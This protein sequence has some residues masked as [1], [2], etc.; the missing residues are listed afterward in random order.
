MNKSRKKY[1]IVF[2]ITISIFIAVF[3]LVDFLDAK[4]RQNISRLQS[5]ITIDLIANETQ[6]DLL[7][8]APCKALDEAILSRQL[9]ELGEKLAYAEETQGV[10]NQAVV[11]LKKYYSLLQVKDYLL[12]QEVSDKCDIQI[13]SL[14][15]FY[16]QD[17]DSCVKQGYVLSE[18][19]RKYPWLRIYSFDRNLDFSIVETFASL[20][21]ISEPAPIIIINEEKYSGFKTVEEIEEYIPALAAK[22][23]LDKRFLEGGEYIKEE[24]GYSTYLYSKEYAEDIYVYKYGIGVEDGLGAYNAEVQLEYSEEKKEF[25]VLS[26]YNEKDE[27][28]EKKNTQ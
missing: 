27:I 25:I 23:E 6:F 24:F 2:I 11:D 16:E 8:N 26:H 5:R 17:C 13:E 21:D 19:K 1:I 28:E 22:K 12:S 7:K 18:L 4:K 3:A 10:R 20:Y 9:G 15:Y 14:I